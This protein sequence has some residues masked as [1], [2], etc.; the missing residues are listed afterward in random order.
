MN[1]TIT[2]NQRVEKTKVQLV[3]KNTKINIDNNISIKDIKRLSKE[4]IEINFK[5][6]IY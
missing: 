6:F 5:R 4:V 2:T 3:I 1:T